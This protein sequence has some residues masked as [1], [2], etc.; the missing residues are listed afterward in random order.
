M[1]QLSQKVVWIT[2]ASSGIG[3]ALAYELSRAG[4][5]LVLSA[6]RP[7]E[8]ERVQKA[9][10][11][12]EQVAVLPLDLSDTD[13]LPGKAVEAEKAFGPIDILVNNGGISQRSLAAETDLAVDRRVFEVNFFGTIALTKALLPGMIARKQGH[14]V[15][16]SSL[17]GVFATPWRSAYAASKHALHGFFDAV[18]AENHDHN[19]QVSIVCPGFVKT[20][21]SYNALTAHGEKLDIMSDTHANAMSAETCA[22]KIAGAIKRNRKEVYIARYEKVGIYIKKWLPALYYKMIRKVKV[23]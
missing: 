14:I 4:S 22:R 21:V 10:A 16:V 13:S 20:N 9:C 8:L 1:T 17:V 6:R 15:V 7:E 5:K 3:E 19:I 12:P 11:Q 23:K 2:G 18:R